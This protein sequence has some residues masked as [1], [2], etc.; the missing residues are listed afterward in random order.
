MRLQC[1][2]WRHLWTATPD[3]FSNLF[4]V[5]NITF[6]LNSERYLLNH[7]TDV[8][9]YP[10]ASAARRVAVSVVRRRRTRFGQLEGFDVFRG[11]GY[12]HKTQTK[13]GMM[14]EESRY[15]NE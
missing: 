6:Y 1:N 12:G 7:G 4:R 3:L 2:R 10:A 14:E 5:C 13:K 15:E 11:L 8:P 9:F